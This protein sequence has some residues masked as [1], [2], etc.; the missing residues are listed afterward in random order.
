VNNQEHLSPNYEKLDVAL[1]SIGYSFESAVADIIDN[2]IDENAQTILVRFVIRK[3]KPLDLVVW[4]D[5]NGMS[6]ETLQEAMR[7][8]ADVTKETDRLGKFGLGMKLA[9]LSQARELKVFTLKN[10]SSSGRGWLEAGIRNGFLCDIFRA[11]DCQTALSE[12]VPDRE[13]KTSGTLVCWSRLYRVGQNRTSPEEHVQKLISRLSNHLSLAFHRFL[14]G[15]ARKIEILLDVFDGDSKTRGVPVY[16]HSLDPFGYERTGKAGFP[17]EM[18]LDPEF[19]DH[20]T[21]TA[22]IWPPNSSEPGYRLPGGANIRQGFYFY[23]KDRLIQGGGWNGIREI[24]PHLSLARIEVHM[25]PNA[26]FESAIGLDIKKV[27]IQLPPSLVRSLINART[28]SG[29]NFKGYLSVADETYRTRI[30]ANT[31]LPLIPSVGLPRDLKDFL[32]KELCIKDTERHRDLHFE[33]TDFPDDSF[34]NIDRDEG[35]LYLNRLYRKQLLHGLNG[36]STDIPVVKCLLFFVLREVIASERL[37]QK[38]REQMELLNR[39]LVKAVK[40]ERWLQ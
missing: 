32:H 38:T 19:N 1:R 5:G 40:H 33:W 2:S 10:G 20:V 4:D 28:A 30:I 29:I 7:F 11:E 3:D 6:A 24:E 27:E 9:S 18:Q 26:D 14:S 35:M 31:D 22:H 21:L 34:F 36:S 25:A 8:G 17:A 37:G 15:K 16:L 39:V 23:R 13:W 12:V